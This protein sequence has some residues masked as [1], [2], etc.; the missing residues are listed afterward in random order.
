MD[1]E[2]VIKTKSLTKIFSQKTIAVNDLWM[3]IP[4]DSVFGFLGPNGSGK[5]TT[6]KLMLGLLHPSAGSVDVFGK[7]M[8]LDS[9]DLR[10]RIGYL[11]T[12]PNFPEKMTPITYLDFIGKIFG[13]PKD[14]R[15]PRV[16]ELIRSVDLLSLSSSEI[17]KFSTGE[18]TRVGIA[19]CLMNDPELLIMDEPT[20]GLDPVG[21]ASIVKLI[22]ELGNKKGKTV[23]VSSHI[24]ADID[25]FCSRIGIISNGK[26]IFNG[27]ITEVKK[28]IR[29]NTIELQVEGK[30]KPFLRKLKT[31]PNVIHVD[32]SKHLIKIGIDDSTNYSKTLLNIFKTLSEEDLELISFNSG[33]DNLEEAF[34]NLLEEE[35]SHGFLRTIS[36]NA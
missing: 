24:L 13:I 20:L 7:P 34:L 16:A 2:S 6:I 30:A 31:I 4:R 12:Q 21:R 32:Y 18:I 10:R 8:G 17:K 19:T 15:I 3:D 29:R 11:P 35:K 9:A 36:K 33:S 28:L 27:T 5:T 23:F 1:M 25:R 22:T 14:T 26:L